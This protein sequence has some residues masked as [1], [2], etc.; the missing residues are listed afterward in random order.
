MLVRVTVRERAVCTRPGAAQAEGQGQVAAP[1][2]TPDTP[3]TPPASARPS[4]TPPH[5][6]R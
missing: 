2:K 4:A 5:A 1:P 3:L 6:P